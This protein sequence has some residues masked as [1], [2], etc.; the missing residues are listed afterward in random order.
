[1]TEGDMQPRPVS[2]GGARRN[3]PSCDGTDVFT[4]RD[5]RVS[6]IHA[7]TRIYNEAIREG[8][9]TSDLDER[10]MEQRRDWLERHTPRSRYPVVVVRYRGQTIGFGS[11]SRYRPRAGYDSI[12]ELSYY[13]GSYWRGRGAGRMLVDW[14]L[15]RARDLGYEKAVSC[16]FDANEGSMH[17]MESFGL[18]RFGVL[19]AAI[20]NGSR[21]LDVVYWY[22]DLRPG[23]PSRPADADRRGG[24]HDDRDNDNNKDNNNGI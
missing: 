10:S 6:D 15:H 13:V 22:K 9:S 7:I 11:L 18:T 21:V 24:S 16:V 23:E 12:V 1:M 8:V 19:P 2:H 4:I 20:R 17:L 5:A 3:G 14:L